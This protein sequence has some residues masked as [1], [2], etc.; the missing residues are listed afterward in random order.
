MGQGE[1]ELLRAT[2][3]EIDGSILT[4]FGLATDNDGRSSQERVCHR[5]GQARNCLPRRR[6]RSRRALVRFLVLFP[7][8]IVASLIRSSPR[9]QHERGL[10]SSVCYRRAPRERSRLHPHA[11]RD[12]QELALVFRVQS[13]VGRFPSPLLFFIA[14]LI[15]LLFRLDV[16]MGGRVAEELIY[17]R[18]NVTD[19]ASSVRPPPTPFFLAPHP[20]ISFFHNHR[21]SPMRPRWPHTWSAGSV[22]PT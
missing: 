6:S 11:S 10:P 13:Q 9:P 4:C 7:L 12:G 8:P 3:E 20:L 19:G 18:D 1:G 16:A 22:S 17:G 21:T 5:E 15:F 2:V 14:V